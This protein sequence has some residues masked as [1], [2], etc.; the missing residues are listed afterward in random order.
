MSVRCRLLE[1]YV[2]KEK[3][4]AQSQGL[5]SEPAHRER[6]RPFAAA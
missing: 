1:S 4:P 6:K 2:K 3:A 5:S